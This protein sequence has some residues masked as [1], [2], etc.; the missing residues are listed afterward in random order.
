MASRLGY[1]PA[2]TQTV[3]EYTGMLADLVPRAKDPLGLVA[4]AQVEVIYGRRHLGADRL[5]T[6]E[7][8]RRRVRQALLRLVFRLP[9]RRSGA[10]AKGKG[11]GR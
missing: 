10:S 3:Y 9:M 1:K 6:L 7:S 11:K 4:T 5:A 2:P 8:A